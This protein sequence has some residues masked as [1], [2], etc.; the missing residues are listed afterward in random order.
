MKMV[1]TL[2]KSS[3]VVH[4]A[5]R[6]EY[7]SFF[8]SDTQPSIAAQFGNNVNMSLTGNDTAKLSATFN[9]LAKEEKKVTLTPQHASWVH[10]LDY[11]SPA[12][13]PAGPVE[14]GLG[15]VPVEVQARVESGWHS[16]LVS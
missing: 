16:P 15:G 4:A 14:S 6:T 1:G 5:L 11:R 3:L 9:A 7:L 13:R 12:S 2:A 10:S 8:A